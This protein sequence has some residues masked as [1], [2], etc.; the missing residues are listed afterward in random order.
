MLL[1]LVFHFF[2]SPKRNETKKRV[3]FRMNFQAL[4][5]TDYGTSP[6]MAMPFASANRSFRNLF[7]E[8]KSL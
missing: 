8:K 7:A 2:C 1:F 3:L 5:E 4:P 6:Q